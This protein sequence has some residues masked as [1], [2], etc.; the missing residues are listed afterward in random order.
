MP[1]ELENGMEQVENDE[2]LIDRNGSARTNGIDD[3]NDP[4]NEPGDN[5][6]DFSQANR[7]D[8]GRVASY[9]VIRRSRGGFTMSIIGDLTGRP[10]THD[11]ENESDLFRVPFT[12]VF[13]SER[14]PFQRINRIDKS[15][16][17]RSPEKLEEPQHL[18]KGQ[19]RRVI[20]LTQRRQK[21]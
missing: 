3:Q 17:T 16:K 2:N 14:Q 4:T 1:N 20:T 15:K 5:G 21:K 6:N 8:F 7:P 9:F 18:Q 13:P 19:K 10:T 12:F 11:S